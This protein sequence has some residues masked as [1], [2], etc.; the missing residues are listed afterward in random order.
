MTTVT[1]LRNFREDRRISMELYG[2]QLY[3]A[4][5]SCGR[6]SSELQEFRPQLGVYSDIMPETENMKMRA[7]RY[8]DYPRQVRSLS[9][10][11]FHVL[12]H[13]Y[14]HLMRV[15]DPGRVVVTVHDV[16]PLLTGRGLVPGVMP[17]RRKW[18]AEYSNSFLKK[19]GRLI[20]DSQST[21]QNIIEYC[22]C[23]P[24]KID[25]IYLGINKLYTP[26]T[27]ASKEA[28]R[29]ALGLPCNETR[30]VLITGESFYKNQKTSV[31]VLDKLW[32]AG[33]ENVMLVRLGVLSPNWDEALRGT[34]YRDR[35]I[36]IDW[37]SSE[38]VARLYNA[39]D[40]LL[41]PSWYEGF[42][43]PPLEAMACGTPAITSNR[44]SLPEVVGDVGPV[45]D[46]D[47]VEGMAGAIENLLCQEDYRKAQIERGLQHA[48]N[49]NWESTAIQVSQVYQT[50]L[51][52]RS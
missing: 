52:Q 19:A 11:I 42:G 26:I 51:E 35:I 34:R 15:L 38:D 50:L 48:A 10:D 4:L 5:Q 33:M 36:Q 37:L 49:F 13:G 9:S 32:S 22:D 46:A 45:F 12:D 23:D 30:L 1:Y 20:V 41:F 25:V 47:D 27:D 28:L 3:A 24:Q 40:C 17:G 8:L 16:I 31:Q 2:D 6:N 14:A 21:R 39:V 43:W 29:D 44:A 7:A 18:L